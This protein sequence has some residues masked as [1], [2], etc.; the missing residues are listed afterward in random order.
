MLIYQ[1]PRLHDLNLNKKNNFLFLRQLLLHVD[2]TSLPGELGGNM[3]YSHIRIIFYFVSA[4]A[5]CGFDVFA[6]GAGGQHDLQ[7]H[8]VDSDMSESRPGKGNR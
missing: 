3:T 7:P 2:S 8:S 4:V 5:A 6:R 1:H